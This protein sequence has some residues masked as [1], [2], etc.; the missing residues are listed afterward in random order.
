MSPKKAIVPLLRE[1]D[2]EFERR[3][4]TATAYHRISR[5]LEPGS[6][7]TWAMRRRDGV[8]LGVASLIACVLAFAAFGWLRWRDPADGQAPIA[9]DTLSFE[10]THCTH[11]HAGPRIVL[12][13]ECKLVSDRVTIETW[14]PAV[15]LSEEHALTLEEGR[16][17]VRVEKRPTHEPVELHVSHGTIEVLGTRFLVEQTAERGLV[18]LFEGRIRFRGDDGAVIDLAPGESHAWGRP[19][20][21]PPKR[22]SRSSTLPPPPSLASDPVASDPGTSVPPNPVALNSRARSSARRRDAASRARARDSAESIASPDSSEA[23]ATKLIEEVTRLEAIHRYV[24]ALRLLR[25]SEGEAWDPRTEQVLSYEI[26]RILHRRL[27]DR[28]GA[29]RHLARHQQRFPQGR[30]QVA[31]TDLLRE[32]ECETL[33]SPPGDTGS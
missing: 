13:G 24:E 22:R 2:A 18:Q 29:C 23:A 6:R 32:L 17:L 8:R 25:E 9:M 15:V 33:N 5:S 3:G 16:V 21:P 12:Q 10:G 20:D 1:V 14:D 27:D 30:Y 31:V 4:M 7:R 26:G 19:P 11:E 28:P